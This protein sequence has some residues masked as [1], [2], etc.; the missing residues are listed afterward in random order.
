MTSAMLVNA[1]ENGGRCAGEIVARRDSFDDQSRHRN[2]RFTSAVESQP[3]QRAK[4]RRRRQP[5]GTDTSGADVGK[6]QCLAVAIVA[7]IYRRDDGLAGVAD[8]ADH[9]R[10]RRLLRPEEQQRQQHSHE[11]TQT[12]HVTSVS[13]NVQQQALEVF[14]LR[15]GQRDRM[16]R[17]A[18]QALDDARFATGIEGRA[19]NDL[20][21]QFQ[22]D[23]ARA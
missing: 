11:R 8:V 1:S 9:V 16:V 17:R 2:R 6:V 19:G 13:G 3:W 20:L 10:E 12:D 4:W 18:L 5:G 22:A 23:A 14:A 7:R 15:E 21:E